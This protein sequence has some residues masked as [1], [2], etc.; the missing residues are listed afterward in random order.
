MMNR[1]LLLLII[2]IS[3]TTCTEQEDTIE[4]FDP[5]EKSDSSIVNE[6]DSLMISMQ[7][8]TAADRLIHYKDQDI[9]AAERLYINSKLWRCKLHYA[10]MFEDDDFPALD[11]QLIL[12]IDSFYY[13]FYRT[14]EY[15]NIS[16]LQDRIETETNFYRKI[17]YLMQLSIYYYYRDDIENKDAQRVNNEIYQLLEPL[18]HNTIYHLTLYHEMINISSYARK[19]LRSLALCHKFLDPNRA[20]LP[21]PHMVRARMLNQRILTYTRLDNA[22][23]ATKDVNRN[24][25]LLDSRR[26]TPEY[27][28]LLKNAVYAYLYDS[29][30]DVKQKAEKR[31]IAL[32]SLFKSTIQ[33][34][35]RDYANYH[36]VAG[37]VLSENK[38][39]DLAEIYWRKAL[40][41]FQKQTISQR[42][43]YNSITWHYSKALE[44][45]QKFEDAKSIYMAQSTLQS[46][47][48]VKNKLF[49]FSFIDAARLAS[50]SINQWKKSDDLSHQIEAKRLL[51][52]SYQLLLQQTVNLNEESILRIYESK[53]FLIESALDFIF[54]LYQQNPSN[55]MKEEFYKFSSI[56]K[57]MLLDRD[58][59]LH[60]SDSLI[61]ET[62]NSRELEIKKEIKSVDVTSINSWEITQELLDEQDSIE[63]YILSIYNS[64]DKN[65]NASRKKESL[66]DIQNKLS[67]TQSYIDYYLMEDVLYIVLIN[68]D[69]KKIYKR[70]RHHLDLDIKKLFLVQSQNHK[71]PVIDYQAM[72]YDV[73]SHLI[74]DDIKQKLNSEVIISADGIIHQINVE[75]LVS[76]INK[77]IVEYQDVPYLLHSH[78]VRYSC[79]P[80]HIENQELPS[81]PSIAAFSFSDPATIMASS[82]IGLSELPYAY[83][84]VNRLKDKYPKTTIYAGK[85]A[86]KDQFI[87][88]LEDPTIDIIHLCLHAM[89]HTSNRDDV[90]LYFRTRESG[91][92]SL[93][94]YELLGTKTTVK[95][96]VL[97]ACETGSGNTENN[98]GIFSLYRYFD[99]IGINSQVS[100]LWKVDSEVASELVLLSKREMINKFPEYAHPYYWATFITH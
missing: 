23:Y 87:E 1:W 7:I 88:S 2:S 48:G 94:G 69:E 63:Q 56:K 32:D 83:E 40:Q 59:Q 36:R 47:T 53:S 57:N 38:K 11:T 15:G 52:Q 84:E 89:S 92:D 18:A 78:D 98:E 97:S 25:A 20:F 37:Q 34:C 46:N 4:I 91:I 21:L 24:M 13:V 77:E 16:H 50:I 81:D 27:H 65:L 58:I 5:L 9:T 19:N 14:G 72:A 62:I 64:V 55:H 10:W 70:D 8:E 43:V 90:K 74:G 66:S 33:D 45:N 30:E 76:Q 68:H 79:L 44:A 61:P 17:D 86:T 54:R 96:I 29:R 95:K 82:T 39:F 35:R 41:H 28:I 73:Y 51:D 6:I 3:L 99:Q 100:S 22:E 85:V 93:Y 31:I 75:A 67:P 12:P 71:I 60:Q 26:C 49:T 80:N 42:A